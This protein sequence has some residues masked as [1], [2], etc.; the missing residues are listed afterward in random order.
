MPFE[1][2]YNGKVVKDCIQKYEKMKSFRKVA[3][4]TGVGKSTIVGTSGSVSWLIISIL[5]IKRRKGSLGRLKF[6]DIEE[7]VIDHSDLR[8]ISKTDIVRQLYSYKAI[9]DDWE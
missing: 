3:K 8:F 1:Q 2:Q 4:L 7:N 9:L 6:P 5:P